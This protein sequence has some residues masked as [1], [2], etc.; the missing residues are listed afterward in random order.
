MIEAEVD[1]G[2]NGA[3][4]EV[5]EGVEEEEVEAADAEPSII[6]K[7]KNAFNPEKARL[8]SVY[9]NFPGTNGCPA[10]NPPQTAQACPL[11]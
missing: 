8:T 11:T 9:D 3:A 2:V 7:T 10:L 1:S 6:N 4:D 5:E